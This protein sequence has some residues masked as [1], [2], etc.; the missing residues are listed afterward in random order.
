M[1]FSDAFFQ[2]GLQDEQDAYA[3]PELPMGVLGKICPK[4]F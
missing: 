1:F 3:K 2:A 4:R